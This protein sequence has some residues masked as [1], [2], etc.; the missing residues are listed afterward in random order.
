MASRVQKRVCEAYLPYV[1]DSDPRPKLQAGIQKH[2]LALRHVPVW[3]KGLTAAI[4]LF[5]LLQC[6]F[7]W[8][9]PDDLE[10]AAP[11]DGQQARSLQ[12]RFER[13]SLSGA[14]PA[15]EAVRRA[16]LEV[17]HAGNATVSQTSTDLDRGAAQLLQELVVGK[18]TVACP[19]DNSLPLQMPRS[20]RVMFA[21]DLHNNQHVLPHFTYQMIQI[22]AILGPS[23]VFVSIYESGSTDSTTEWLSLLKSIL[24]QLGVPN[25]IIVDGTETRQKGQ[26]RIDF[27][28]RVRYAA[29]QLLAAFA[30]AFAPAAL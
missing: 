13:F 2:C 19:L 30:C 11:P 9:P 6:F 7:F 4:L 27:L 14:A 28:A 21:V 8:I 24:D 25:R 3:K 16:A 29:P 23:Q 5:I 22:I 10:A 15:A 1:K 20:E 12:D 17:Y 26:D 18:A